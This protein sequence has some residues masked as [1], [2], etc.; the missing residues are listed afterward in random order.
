MRKYIINKS[1]WKDINSLASHLDEDRIIRCHGRFMSAERYKH[2]RRN[3]E[4]NIFGK[5]RVLEVAFAHRISPAIILRRNLTN[6]IP[7][8][9]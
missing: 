9:I 4:M 1:S 2:T 7:D 3:K 6:F 5:K 8:E